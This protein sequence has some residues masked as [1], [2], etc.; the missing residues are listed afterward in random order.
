[1]FSFFESSPK[2]NLKPKL[3]L[4]ALCNLPAIKAAM[5]KEGILESH[6]ADT[7]IN[8]EYLHW[9]IT[10]PDMDYYYQLGAFT[11]SEYIAI[12][13][14]QEGCSYRI[15]FSSTGLYAL[16]RKFITI[17]EFLNL[18]EEARLGMSSIFRDADHDHDELGR[19]QNIIH[20]IFS[21]GFDFKKYNDYAGNTAT[22]V[23]YWQILSNGYRENRPI[24]EVISTIEVPRFKLYWH[25]SKITEEKS[26]I[27]NSSHKPVLKVF[28]TDLYDRPENYI[29]EGDTVSYLRP[30]SYCTMM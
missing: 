18:S 1:M 21:S 11:F 13:P 2:Q 3:T 10:Q 8:L 30:R 6:L 7:N 25:G 26:T 22:P 15:L 17:P 5:D 29:I 14:L 9:F 28:N 27:K 12:S 23:I 19:L 24:A 16:D 20:Y 4:S